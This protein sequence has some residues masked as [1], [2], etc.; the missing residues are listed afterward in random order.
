MSTE[1]STTKEGARVSLPAVGTKLGVESARVTGRFW[2][3]LVGFREGSYILIE[4]PESEIPVGLNAPFSEQDVLT[5]RYVVDGTVVGFRAAVLGRV[6]AP[7][8]LTV[9]AYPRQIQTH[10]LRRYPRLSCHL[11]CRA[12]IGEHELARAM[13]RD[14]SEFG[15][16]VRVA[17]ADLPPD[18]TELPA[19]AIMQIEVEIPATSGQQ[20][21]RERV[22]GAVVGFE[23]QGSYAL[24]RLRSERSL[25]A[26]MN[27]LSA[28]T[29]RVEFGTEP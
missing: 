23:I 12:R 10:S 29:T 19:D 15:C 26:L 28:F 5:I 14:V 8:A 17:V 16:Q 11:P 3:S 1:T 2:S 4:M 25:D 22:E 18:T 13:L 20:S 27:F 7:V 24:I 9:L 6:R 21:N